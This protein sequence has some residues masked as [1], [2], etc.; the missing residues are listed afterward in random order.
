MI[1]V[2]YKQ[3][4]VVLIYHIFFLSVFNQFLLTPIVDRDR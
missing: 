3:G 4:G 2:S 1:L